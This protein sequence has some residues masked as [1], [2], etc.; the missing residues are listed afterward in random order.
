MGVKKPEAPDYFWYQKLRVLADEAGEFSEQFQFWAAVLGGSD[1]QE[2]VD[3]E[4]FCS[5]GPYP[6]IDW[7][8]ENFLNEGTV[9]TLDYYTR[10][11]MY[12]RYCQDT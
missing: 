11:L 2:L 5:I 7:T 6:E 8:I 12:K 3:T 9:E 10:Q 1:S 4:Q